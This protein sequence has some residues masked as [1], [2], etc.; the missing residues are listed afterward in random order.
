MKSPYIQVSFMMSELSALIEV[1]EHFR[2]NQKAN[3]SPVA[4]EI[5]WA[6]NRMF[7]ARREAIEKHISGC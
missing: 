4:M 3:R 7:N 2:D 1:V 6:F 5:E